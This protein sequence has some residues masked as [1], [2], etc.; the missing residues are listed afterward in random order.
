MEIHPSFII[1][2]IFLFNSV[3]GPPGRLEI[4]INGRNTEAVLLTPLGVRYFILKCS[5]TLAVYLF[6]V[7]GQD[8]VTY[9]CVHPQQQ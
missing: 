8:R 5:I 4:T 3:T 1:H 6:Y 2:T 7:V 9:P